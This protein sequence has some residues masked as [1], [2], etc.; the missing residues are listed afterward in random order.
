MAHEAKK[1]GFKVMVGCMAGTSLAMAPAFV[2]GQL[3]D[4]VDLDA[5][6]FLA[7]DREHAVRYA[8]GEVF[9]PEALWGGV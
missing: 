4:I 7:C 3:C 9:C 2:L 6:M 1:L 5:P 8:H